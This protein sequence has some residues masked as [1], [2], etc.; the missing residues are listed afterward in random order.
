[1]IRNIEMPERVIYGSFQFSHNGLWIGVGHTSGRGTVY[2]VSTGEVVWA[3]A[4]HDNYVYNVDFSPDDRNL[5]TGGED[6]MCYLWDLANSATIEPVDFK[7]F[8]KDLIGNSARASFTVHQL[9]V[10][11]PEAAVKAIQSALE[12]LFSKGNEMATGEDV[13]NR[14][15]RA[16]MLLAVLDTPT[17]GTLLDE[18]FE[19]SP[20]L[21]VKKMVFS[22][23]KHRE[24][25][26]HQIAETKGK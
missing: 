15:R 4:K 17:A 20:S 16:V 10:M 24:R 11:N 25:F 26:L 22:A 19:S 8:G 3:E 1:M 2:D 9:L 7:E 13:H 6:G 23:R 12:P 21:I 5:L 14:I 18:L